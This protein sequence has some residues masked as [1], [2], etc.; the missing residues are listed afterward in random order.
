M[1]SYS[2]SKWAG[3]NPVFVV[4]FLFGG[5]V[6]RFCSSNQNSTIIVSDGTNDLL[7]PFGINQLDFL[8][9]IDTLDLGS[10]QENIVSIQLNTSLPLMKLWSQGITLEGVEASVYL[11][12]EDNNGD[13]T[14]TWDNKIKLYQ[15]V[16]EE[17]IFGDPELS[18]GV[19]SFGIELLPWNVTSM[20]LDQNYI[21]TRFS[22]R[23]ESANGKIYP[24][25][26]GNPGFQVVNELNVKVNF[27]AFPVYCIETYTFGNDT[28]FLISSQSVRS[29]SINVYDENDKI[30]LDNVLVASDSYNQEYSYV[31]FP[32]G[33]G[34]ALPGAAATGVS[35]AWWGVFATY[36]GGISNPYRPGTALELAGDIVRWAFALTGQ[37]VDDASFANISNVL[38]RYK[39][40]GYINDGSITG[41]DWIAGNILPLL[42]ISIRMGANGVKP[43]L[44]TLSAITHVESIASIELGNDLECRQSS[45]VQVIRPTTDIV[46]DFSLL[47]GKN[48]LTQ[49]YTQVSRCRHIAVDPQDIVSEY[50]I[51][52]TSRYGIKPQT[53]ESDYIYDRATANLIAKDIVRDRSLVVHQMEI[54]M[55]IYYGY[56]QVGDVLSVSSDFLNLSDHK[57]LIVQKKWHDGLINWIYILQFELN[58]IQNIRSK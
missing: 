54:E 21:D 7:I 33:A 13:I 11:L 32:V 5:S 43:V 26:F 44:N 45:P 57:M 4:E 25:V 30:S 47:W 16:I 49:E 14:Q 9:S 1:Y 15:G 53:Y 55:P 40:A 37:A 18:E 29:T 34:I 19:V 28:F 41:W 23:D 31:G 52:S 2:K 27:P 10:I 42:P 51:L 24:L 39:L 48:G 46:N 58:P 35:Q 8:E 12:L 17:P 22:T 56:L 20:L 38:N 50:A 6:R 3:S 36:A